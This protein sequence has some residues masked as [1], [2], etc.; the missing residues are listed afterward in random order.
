[1]LLPLL[2]SPLV[3]RAQ[4]IGLMAP[5]ADG[6]IVPAESLTTAYTV[7]GLQVIQ[8]P[9]Y[10]NEVVSV[11]LYLLGGTRQLTPATAGIERLAIEAA[12]S[13]TRRYPG[14]RSNIA[15]RRTGSRMWV[16]TD[17]DWT[18]FAFTGLDDQFDSTWTV[19]ADRIV[20]PTL[21]S[22]AV[23]N[24]RERLRVAIRRR[25]EDP[26][27]WVHEIADSVV[28]AG[29]PY[30]IDPDG[31]P[32]SMDA[33]TVADVRRYVAE[34]F[35]TSRM[36]LVIVGTVPRE[37][38]ETAVAATLGT[39]PR[40]SYTWTPP[41]PPPEHPKATITVVNH[42]LNTNY[43][44][45]YYAGP[46]V[47]SSDYAAFHA[48]T[49]LLS[50]R[51][52]SA[53]RERRSLSYD[54]GA[55]YYD[56]AIALGG[57]YASSVAP[58]LVVPVMRTQ[59]QVCQE[60]PSSLGELREFLDQFITDYYLSH[61]TNGEQASE[62]ARAQI[63]RGDY[64]RADAEFDAFR[65]VSVGDIRAAAQKYIRHIQFVYLGNASQFDPSLI[66]GF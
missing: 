58:S 47:T 44:L 29:H 64:R 36:L 27:V 2:A 56:H 42:G 12:A 54:V 61:E 1:V 5:A 20:A 65:R 22:S 55:P 18:E 13:G 15:L 53:V 46:T 17:V 60:E 51:L 43:L 66:K 16:Y 26:D 50:G 6:R 35:V 9:A 38:V 14:L 4:H 31:T 11:H 10:G 40:G 52:N 19:F 57:V 8:R 28:F 32:E 45:G 49:E 7:H 30:G 62:L 39:L 25:R 23:T 37:R 59:I 34:Q 21:D 24:A 63:Y 33:L 3:A 41:P 48:A